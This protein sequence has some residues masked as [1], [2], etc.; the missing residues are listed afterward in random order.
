MG[1]MNCKRIVVGGLLGGLCWNVWSIIVNDVLLSGSYAN[2][3]QGGGLLKEPRHG[4]VIFIGVWIVI[5]LAMGIGLAW[6][7]AASRATLG[8]GPVS[9]LKVGAVAGVVAGVPGNF[10]QMNWAPISQWVPLGWMAEM[11]L[12]CILAT[13]VAGWYYRES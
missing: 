11:V 3:Q 5:L 1:T 12:G 13:L 6:L 8:P 9:A 4:I 2:E 10:A 7:Y